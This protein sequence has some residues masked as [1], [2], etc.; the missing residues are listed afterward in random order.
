MK[1]RFTTRYHLGIWVVFILALAI[2][3]YGIFR[4]TPPPELFNNSDKVGHVIAFLGVSF[5]GR[6][7]LHSIPAALYWGIWFILAGLLEYLQHE[8]RP[9]R[10]FSLQ[11]AYANTAGVVIAIIATL[12]VGRFINQRATLYSL[13]PDNDDLRD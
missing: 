12:L 11:D 7:A 1:N 5:V 9:E 6:L 8:F 3:A 10:Y 13:P 4:P 2:L